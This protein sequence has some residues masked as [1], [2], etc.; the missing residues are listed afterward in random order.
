MYRGNGI[1]T[2]EPTPKCK[3]QIRF[4]PLLT[5]DAGGT[6]GNKLS[7]V[8]SSPQCKARGIKLEVSA[9]HLINRAMNKE[10]LAA[11]C[12][13]EAVALVS[14]NCKPA[15]AGAREKARCIPRNNIT[16][17]I[18]A[19]LNHKLFIINTSLKSVSRCLWT[20]ESRDALY[21]TIKSIFIK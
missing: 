4:S 21:E 7:K 20:C 15:A 19:V 6:K 8:F 10:N 3:V 9:L 11:L 5:R 17:K 2:R 14:L 1:E 12:A 18:N 13:S 16:R